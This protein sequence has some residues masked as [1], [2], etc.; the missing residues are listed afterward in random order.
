MVTFA[1]QQRSYKDLRDLRKDF[2]PAVGGS[3]GEQG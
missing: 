2:S 3:V 1:Q